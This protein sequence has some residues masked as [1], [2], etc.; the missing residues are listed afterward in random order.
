MVTYQLVRQMKPVTS[1]LLHGVVT[2]PPVQSINLLTVALFIKGL[3]DSNIC[4][5]QEVY[6]K[7]SYNLACVMFSDFEGISF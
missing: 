2:S 3:N 4:L 5:I 1:W 6:I 7:K